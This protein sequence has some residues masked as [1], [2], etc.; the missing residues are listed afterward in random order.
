MCC[1][2]S[3]S[4]FPLWFASAQTLRNVR[5]ILSV[6]LSPPIMRLTTF[7]GQSIK[8]NTDKLSRFL[9]AECICHLSDIFRIR[10]LST[11]HDISCLTTTP[12]Q[13][14]RKLRARAE[15]FSHYASQ[16]IAFHSLTSCVCILSTSCGHHYDSTSSFLCQPLFVVFFFLVVDFVDNI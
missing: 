15:L 10:R 13:R 12:A 9:Y 14:H 7:C 2:R 5:I 1:S 3:P 6:T 16:Y 8:K 11:T 4:A